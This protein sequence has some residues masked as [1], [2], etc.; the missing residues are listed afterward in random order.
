MN[1]NID[2]CKSI[3]EKDKEIYAQAGKLPYFPL[4]VK[5]GQ[6][7]II[8]DADGNQYIDMLASA[9]M[10]NTGHCHPKIVEA[11]TNQAK[12]FVHYIY[13]YVY[14]EP[15]VEL[16]K[17]I[18]DITPGNFEKRIIFGLTGSDANDGMIK[19]ARAYTGRSKIISFIGSY[20]GSTYGA[21]S[22][23]ALNLN[24]RRKIGPLLPEI[25]HI[26]YPDCYRCRF[27][28]KECTCNLECINELENAFKYYLAPEEVAAILIEPIAGDAGFIVPP[29]KYMDKL[30]S[31]CKENGILFV[32]DEVQQ[33][34]GR[35]GEWFGIDN[36]NIEPDMVVLG[37]SIAS[38]MPMSAI[39]GRK[40]IMESLD[41]PAH[42]F[43]GT[44]NP[45]SCKAATAT[46]QVIR[47]EKLIERSKTLGEYM[48]SRFIEMQKKY[49]IIGD[50]R[51]VGMTIGVDLVKDRTTKERDTN[52]A[53]KICYRAWENGVL[54]TFVSSNVLR[55][56]P[57]LVINKEQIDRALDII[58]NSIKSYLN[59]EISDEVLEISK[60]W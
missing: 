13:P 29:K 55:I 50:V 49:E 45:L 44:A 19:F 16:A 11:I 38:G 56:Q 27:E 18:I 36:F 12:D 8:E 54:V 37:K 26:H 10:L 48:K 35:T 39:V 47:E 46:L 22:L 53:A 42:T 4:A 15:L 6:G 58:E 3:V 32:V 20:H 25:H 51:G 31:I 60:G 34:F 33:G 7:A 14:H 28:K 2:K 52:A 57:P 21:I 43:T 5:K 41:A 17:Q 30:Y 40:E 59:N 9:A 24:M 1:K 23:S